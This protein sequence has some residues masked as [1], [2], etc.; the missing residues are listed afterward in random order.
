MKGLEF[1]R[2]GSMNRSIVMVVGSLG[3]GIVASGASATAATGPD[4]PVVS[5]EPAR[6]KRDAAVAL[7]SDV[8]SAFFLL[9]KVAS[10]DGGHVGFAGETTA[11][12]YAF[13]T[14][15]RSSQARELFERLTRDGKL[16]GQLYGLCGLLNLDRSAFE[17]LAQPFL[18]SKQRIKVASGCEVDRREVG[19]F[20]A[21]AVGKNAPGEFG[22]FCADLMDLPSDRPTHAEIVSSMKSIQPQVDACFEVHK[23]RGTAMVQVAIAAGGRL[24]SATVSGKL[25]KTPVGQCVEAAIGT[26]KFPPWR[27]TTFPW[28]YRR[29]APAPR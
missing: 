3:V 21:S 10:L 20:V 5:S 23:A 1:T 4:A 25:A 6:Q 12:V 18:T 28:S 13:R 26:I 7:P 27:A 15:A 19:A 11:A 16:A 24:V 2:S 17:R 22:D 8:A 14:V 29:S 9:S